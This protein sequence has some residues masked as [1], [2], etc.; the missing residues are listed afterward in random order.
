MKIL[1]DDQIRSGRDLGWNHIAWYDTGMAQLLPGSSGTIGAGLSRKKVAPSEK[2]KLVDWFAPQ[3][4][5]PVLGLMH[6]ISSY[7]LP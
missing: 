7:E 4:R 1:S 5:S 3:L 2:R 6:N